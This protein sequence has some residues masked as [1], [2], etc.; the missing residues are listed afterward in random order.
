MISIFAVVV[1]A[2]LGAAFLMKPVIREAQ[3]DS[4]PMHQGKLELTGTAD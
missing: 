2:G 1:A 3:L 4:F